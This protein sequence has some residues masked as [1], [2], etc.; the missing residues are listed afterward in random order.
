MIVLNCDEYKMAKILVE[1]AEGH[2]KIVFTEIMQRLK[3]SRRQ[4]GKPL[5]SIG[6]KCLEL[7]LPIIT[8][9]AVYKTNGQV[10]I[11]YEEFEPDYKKHPEK[12]IA[13]QNAVWVCKEWDKLLK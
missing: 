3:I 10:G 9:L 5:S 11:G 8:V 12:V 13:M 2:R 4:L 7:G 6:Q 1:A